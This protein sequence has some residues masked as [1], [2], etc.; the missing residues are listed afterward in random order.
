MLSD[1]R[2]ILLHVAERRVHFHCE[3]YEQNSATSCH[4]DSNNQLTR[5]TYLTVSETVSAAMSSAALQQSLL[6]M[7]VYQTV[8]LQ[9]SY[10]ARF[11]PGS[12]ARYFGVQTGE[13]NLQQLLLLPFC[14][15]KA[16]VEEGP[17]IDTYLGNT[18]VYKRTSRTLLF[19]SCP[20]IGRFLE[21]RHGGLA[22]CLPEGFSNALAVKLAV[23]Y[24]E[25]YLLDP[26][27]RDAPWHVRDDFALYIDLA[28]LFKFIGMSHAARKLETAI[29][30]RV[31]ETSLNISQICQIWSREY[32]QQP[33]RYAEAMAD[34]IFTFICMAEIE[35][36]R[37]EYDTEPTKRCEERIK[38]AMKREAEANSDTFG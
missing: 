20:D 14:E 17:Y 35:H 34:N 7:Q 1:S 38:A 2:C 31:R 15:R 32:T 3:V 6:L 26:K 18:R 28:E 36:F 24:T 5:N 23:L 22:I 10:R 33:S 13:I 12:D 29:I 30:G 8:A 25:Q 27:V 11:A 37:I 4:F 9:A 16:V 21:P 19:A